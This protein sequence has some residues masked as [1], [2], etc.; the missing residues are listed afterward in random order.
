MAIDADLARRIKLFLGGRAYGKPRCHRKNIIKPSA[1]TSCRPGPGNAMLV[2]KFIS[3][4]H[5]NNMR[6][7]SEPERAPVRNSIYNRESININVCPL[8]LN[9]VC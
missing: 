2:A 5:E 4:S 3:V 7:L 9:S 6:H 8:A 1:A